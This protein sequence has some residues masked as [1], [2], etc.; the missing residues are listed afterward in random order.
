MLSK[1]A[2]AGTTPTEKPKNDYALPLIFGIGGALIIG[3]VIGLLV[4]RSR[5]VKNN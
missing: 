4:A 3:V 2:N 1:M 5:K